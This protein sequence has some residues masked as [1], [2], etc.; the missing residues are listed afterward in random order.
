MRISDYNT[1]IFDWD[2]TLSTSTFIVHLTKFFKRR[3]GV[4]YIT[5]HAREYKKGVSDSRIIRSAE[6]H[7]IHSSAIYEF[8]YS[9]YL[10]LGKPKP[11]E[12][13][14]ELLKHLKKKGKQIAVFSDAKKY[15]LVRELRMLG[16]AG[17]IDFIVSADEIHSFKPYPTGINIAIRALRSRKGTS[18]YIGDMPVDVFTAKFAG[19]ASCAVLGG[20][21][22]KSALKRAKPD[23]IFDSLEAIRKALG[24]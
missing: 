16:M 14:V 11:R 15:R 22:S 6:E 3:Y 8:L 20:M 13:S 4:D 10:I 18:I 23:F 19:I 17:Y 12:G 1:F 5:A 9:V 7:E 24:N 2:G 21:S